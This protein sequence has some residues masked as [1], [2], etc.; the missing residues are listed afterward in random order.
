MKDISSR[1]LRGHSGSS[2]DAVTKARE[3]RAMALRLNRIADE[4][5]NNPVAADAVALPH[6][7]FA[8]LFLDEAS[9]NR[10]SSVARA[11][12][13]AR[14]RRDRWFDRGLFGEPGWDILLDAFQHKASGTR[15]STKSVCLA[16]GVAPTTALRWIGV[17]EEGGLLRRE[18]SARDRREM[19]VE[20][21]DEGF[22]AM[23]LYLLE[24]DRSSR[25]ASILKG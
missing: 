23:T 1:S 12:H 5:E 13:A 16:S 11:I 4:I 22:R 20:L 3:L 15:L 14:R 25:K 7:P 8:P 9:S 17:L 21:T 18:P 6:E 24:F 19:M 10:L 2:R